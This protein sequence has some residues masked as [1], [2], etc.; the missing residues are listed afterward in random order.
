MLRLLRFMF[1]FYLD[2]V[3][4]LVK[5]KKESAQRTLF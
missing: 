3:E 5:V 4:K 1:D 2:R